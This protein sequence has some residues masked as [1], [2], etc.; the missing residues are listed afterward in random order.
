MNQFERK[1]GARMPRT[2]NV[3]LPPSSCGLNTTDS[4]NACQIPTQ[5]LRERREELRQATKNATEFGLVQIRC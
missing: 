1:S 2:E 3:S 4:T 5:R